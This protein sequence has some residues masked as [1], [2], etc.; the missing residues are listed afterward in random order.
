VLV[1]AAAGGQQ[2]RHVRL[3][4]GPWRFEDGWHLVPTWLA[5][6]EGR[7]LDAPPL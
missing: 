1:V 6:D 3:G 7:S 4:Y 2:A 5:D